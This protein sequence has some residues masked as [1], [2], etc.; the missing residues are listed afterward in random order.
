M[1]LNHTLEIFDYSQTER[2]F[3]MK[4][5]SGTLSRKS[6]TFLPFFARPRAITLGPKPPAGSSVRWHNAY[7]RGDEA[8]RKGLL[9]K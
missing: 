5:R 2:R 7:R 9:K 4:Q 1:Y 6:G 8:G 3:F